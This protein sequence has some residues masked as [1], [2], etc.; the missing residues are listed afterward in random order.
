V[1]ARVRTSDYENLL[2]AAKGQLAQVQAAVENAKLNYDR[3]TNLFASQSLTKPDLDGAKAKYDSSVAMVTSAQ[4]QVAAAQLAI[5]DCSIRAPLGGWVLSRSVEVG[6]LVSPASPAFAL[7]DL[8]L[9]KAV[10]GVP[11]IAIARV[12]LGAIQTLSTEA[13][14]GEFQGRI[15]AISP[16]ADPK[17]R[18]FSVE[19]TIPN[20]HAAL[21]A[22]MVATLRMGGSKLATPVAV[23][24]LGAVVRSL[25]DP[26]KFAALVVEDQAGKSVARSRDIQVG[27][28]YGNQIGVTQGLSVG[29]RVITVGTSLI[30]DGEQVQVMP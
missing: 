3:A 12:K 25:H 19:I 14:T 22:G 30:K 10:F 21:R 9:V 6:S 28:T 18:V 11:D 15:T 23:I 7:A 1:L 29:D 4:A 8:H 27:D 16:A 13:V 26:S 5:E 2:N 24:P 20:P 17:S